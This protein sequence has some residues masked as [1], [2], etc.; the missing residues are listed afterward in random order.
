MIVVILL[1]KYFFIL[2]YE[3]LILPFE[4]I[5]INET[6]NQQ[7]IT[8]ITAEKKTK[9][10]FRSML[11]F[12]KG[13]IIITTSESAKLMRSIVMLVGVNALTLNSS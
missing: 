10:R 3:W 12:N 2:Y 7:K 1:I 4:E 8:K 11:V 6:K 13:I 5:L 9:T